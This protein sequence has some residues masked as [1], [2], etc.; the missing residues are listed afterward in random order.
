MYQVSTRYYFKQNYINSLIKTP[1]I[2][3]ATNPILLFYI[4]T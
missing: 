3:S 2:S 1:I 4:D